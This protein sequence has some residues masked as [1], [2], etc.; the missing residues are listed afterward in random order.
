[1]TKEGE[2]EKKRGKEEEREVEEK[3]EER[4]EERE[5]EEQKEEQ[6]NKEGGSCEQ[7][8]GISFALSSGFRQHQL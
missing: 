3:K 6:M 2:G 1:M 7:G 8:R 4:E 5:V